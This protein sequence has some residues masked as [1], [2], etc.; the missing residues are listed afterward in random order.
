MRTLAT[1]LALTLMVIQ[2]VGT[3]R[4]DVLAPGQKGIDHRMVFVGLDHHTG[5]DFHLLA[6]DMWEGR[7][8][9]IADGK[10]LY[11][12]KLLDM[13]LCAVPAGNPAPESRQDPAIVARSDRTFHLG[14][15]EAETSPV[16]RRITRFEILVVEDG[17]ITVSD[18]QVTNYDASGQ[19]ISPTAV[20]AVT[21]RNPL[22]LSV[23]ALLGVVYVAGRRM[24]GAR[25]S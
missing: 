2:P 19:I 18:A 1:A 4:G 21:H 17:R 14:Q 11:F 3:A 23:L 8:V 25:A 20:A 15:S 16:E 24:R 5:Y 13:Q 12:Y 6:P 9:R 10:P 7:D 22:M